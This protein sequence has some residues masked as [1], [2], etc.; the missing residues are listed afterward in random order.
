MASPQRGV[1][2]VARE[3][4]HHSLRTI[5]ELQNPLQDLL[6][7]NHIL[8]VRGCCAAPGGEPSLAFCDG[9]GGMGLEEVGRR[10]ERGCVYNDG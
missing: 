5:N 2:E 1:G 4:Q 10:G 6:R 9:L 3:G 8:L 7:K